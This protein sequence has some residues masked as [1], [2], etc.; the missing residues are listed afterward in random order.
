MFMAKEK[1]KPFGSKVWLASPTMHGD[2]L[3]YMS[4]AYETNWMSTVGENINEIERVISEKLGVK[5]AV[6]LSAGTASLHLALKLAGETIYGRA[7]VG[8]GTLN[9]HLVIAV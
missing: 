5:Y 2:E 6:A 4:E 1:I 9:N 3:K 8:K 7:K